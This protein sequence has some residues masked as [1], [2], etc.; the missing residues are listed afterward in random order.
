MKDL[1]DTFWDLY[2]RKVSK[3]MAHRSFYKLTPAEREQAVEALPN[4]VAY[5]K[6]KNTE[7]DYVPHCT[8]WLNQYRFEDE[9]VI[10]EPKVNKRPELPFYATEELTMKKA[11]EVGITPYAG[12]GWSALRMRISNKIKQLEGQL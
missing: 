5:W 8:T 1:F 2:P 10:E 12:E 9:I 3:R 4:H 7:L 6:S 11:N